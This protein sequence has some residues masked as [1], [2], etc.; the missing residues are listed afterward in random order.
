M[1]PLLPDDRH[2]LRQQPAASGH[3]VREDRRRRHRPLQ[4]ARAAFDTHFLMG[5]DEHSQNVFQQ[6]RELGLDPLAYCDRMEQEFRDVWR[7]LDISFDDFIRTTEP[8]HKAGGAGARPA[9]ARRRRHLRRASTR[10]GTASPARPSSRRRIS[11]T[12]LCPIH[13]D[14]AGVDPREE[15]LLPAVEVPASR[16]SS[17]SQAHPEF[18]EPE[19]R[20]NE[21]LRLLEGGLEDISVSRAGQAWGIPLP[22]DPDE[23]RLRLVR[24]ADQLRRGGRLRHRR[25]AVREVVA[26]R[27]A[28][29]RQGH[30]ALPLRHLAGDADERRPAAAATGVRPRLGALQGPADE[31]VARARSSIRSTR[32]ER[33]GADPLRLY[34]VKEIPFGGDGDFTWE[35]FEER[36]NVDLANNL[37]NLVSRV[38]AMAEKYRDG[39]LASAGA[40]G[41]LARSRRRR[42]STD[43]RGDG[44]ASRSTKA[45]RR[46]FGW[47][48]RPTSS[49]PR[50]SR[51]RSPAIPP[52][53][54]LTQ[55]LFDVAEAVRVAAVLLLPVMPASARRDPAARRRDD[56]AADDLRLDDAAWRSDGE[57]VL[58]K[59]G[60]TVAALEPTVSASQ[61]AKISSEQRVEQP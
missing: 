18:I 55:V 49:S 48:T 36:Y 52:A 16:C 44:R 40:P 4:A 29:H 5:N 51:G 39:R 37:G 34:L 25:G 24:R 19:M 60:A 9:D 21:I 46:R 27:P 35:R 1:C 11:S 13:R 61:P 12:A 33:F 50:P 42:R 14:E 31:Q 2:R 45:S 26:G 58:I 15:L 3:G 38:T 59:G 6:A 23:R 54:R 30:H 10:A 28:R 7:A 17:T 41:R 56:A 53:R 57:R 43:Y 8:R 22:F 20:R 47:S 32:V